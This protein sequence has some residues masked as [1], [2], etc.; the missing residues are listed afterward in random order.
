LPLPPSLVHFQLSCPLCCCTTLHFAVYCSGVFWGLR[1]QSAQG[2]CWFIPGWLGEFH[3]MCDAHLFGLFNVSPAGLEPVAASAVAVAALKFS[4]HYVL[5]GSLAQARGSGYRRFDSGWC[6]TSSKCGCN[7]SLG[8]LSR[9]SG[10]L[11][12]YCS[13]HLGSLLYF[14]RQ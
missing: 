5:W 12:P 8:F 2:L 13:H 3:L 1:G 9:N 10:Y 4:Q 11:L 7:I 14:Y 6:F